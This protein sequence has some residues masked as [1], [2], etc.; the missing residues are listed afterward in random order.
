MW[1]MHI[2]PNEDIQKLAKMAWALG[3][4][5]EELQKENQQL[6]NEVNNLK[7]N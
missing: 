2:H 4:A 7:R 5:V 6:K 3:E 1:A